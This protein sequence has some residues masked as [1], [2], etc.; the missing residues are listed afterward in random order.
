[1]NGNDII[2]KIKKANLTGRGGASFAVHLKWQ[3]VKDAHGQKTYIVCNGSEGEL[4]VYKDKYILENHADEVINGIKIALQTF[5]NAQ[6]IIYLNK[7]Y[8]PKLN[9]KLKRLA[10]K[11]PI[12]IYRK[13]GEYIAGEETTLLEAIENKP[14]EPRIKPPYPAQKGL[15]GYPTLINNVETFYCISKIAKGQYKGEKFYSIVGDVRHPGTY[16]FPETATIKEIINRTHNWPKHG[17]FMRS[18]NFF[19]QA[20]GGAT[21]EIL[22]PKELG[23]H[24]KG[25]GSI[26]I[27]DR[28]KTD[29]YKLMETWADFFVKGNCDKCVPCREGS[30]RILEMIKHRKIDKQKLEELYFS[31]EQTSFC[32]LGKSIPTAFRSLIQKLN[33]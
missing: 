31:L 21:G 8:Y 32:P 17:L 25:V 27:Y 18:E 5:N 13:T 12:T 24:I 28:K 2:D 7:K 10:G 6:A 1:M 29:P 14:H 22:L 23:T 19:V 4:N 30:Y 16:V 15:Y 33:L 26:I 20:G 9:Q 11:S 3:A